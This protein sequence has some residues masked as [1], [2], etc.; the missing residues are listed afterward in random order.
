M[1]GALRM[2]QGR[3]PPAAP[4]WSPDDM[5]SLAGWWIAGE[6]AYTD[7]ARTTLA[8][9]GDVVEGLEDQSGNGRH[10]SIKDT[11]VSPT[12]Q[13]SEFNGLDVLRFDGT[14]HQQL[15]TG[16]L[17]LTNSAKQTIAALVGNV[18]DTG[19]GKNLVANHY[20]SSNQSPTLVVSSSERAEIY[21]GTT[22]GGGSGATFGAGGGYLV[23]LFDGVSSEVRA[24][25]SSVATGDAGTGEWLSY[26]ISGWR[27][28]GDPFSGD[29]IEVCVF[30]NEILTGADLDGLEDYFAYRGGFT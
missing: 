22:I 20:G 24:N 16:S 28:G 4:S 17:T 3:K 13:T 29:I 14:I 8:G 12:L 6:G 1:S 30:D 18:N 9:D 23:G 15:Q 27:T 21:A 11:G 25:G 5:A 19:E 26:S 2:M 7:A 10:L